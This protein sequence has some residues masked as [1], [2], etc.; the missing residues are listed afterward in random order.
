MKCFNQRLLTIE[1]GLKNPKD[2]PCWKGYKP[3]GTKTKNGRTVPNCVPKESADGFFA[4]S[5]EVTDNLKA[6][7]KGFYDYAVKKLGIQTPP[8]LVLNK[9]KGRVLELRS[10]A[11]YM[12]G[13]NKIWVYIGN[14]NAADVIRSLGHELVH[15]KQRE[16]R[17]GSDQSVID[18]S[19][20]SDDENEANSVAGVLLRTYGKM[21][22]KI[23]E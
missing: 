6:S 15:V 20:G 13:I 4:E 21:N 17:S 11:G 3:V 10:M 2:N 18:G 19:T 7:V 5:E 14:R 22:S 8:R 12:P 16:G 9:D 23:Y 1:E